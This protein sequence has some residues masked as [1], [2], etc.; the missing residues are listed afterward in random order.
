MLIEPLADA[1]PHCRVP[2]S[3]L[4][5]TL[6]LTYSEAGLNKEGESKRKG[7]EIKYLTQ[8][9][10]ILARGQVKF[11]VGAAC[12]QHARTHAHV[13]SICTHLHTHTNDENFNWVSFTVY[14]GVVP[15]GC[16]GH[17]TK[18]CVVEM[19]GNKRL[20]LRL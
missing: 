11:V 9:E 15:E 6:S 2:I 17:A 20:L 8:V 19:V 5:T 7:G 12:A 16:I 1:S 18:H 14:Y 10:R 3:A 4:G 13:L